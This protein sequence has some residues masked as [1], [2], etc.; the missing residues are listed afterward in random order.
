MT[1]GGSESETWGKVWSSSDHAAVLRPTWLPFTIDV[2]KTNYHVETSG[3]GLT[4]YL[5]LYTRASG[6]A[7]Q[8]L[9][10]A[11]GP[12]VI[13]G[14]RGPDES[15]D[16]VVVRGQGAQLLTSP[17]GTS[18][19]VWSEGGIR[20]TVQGFQ[21]TRGELLKIVESLMPVLDAN[22][23]VGSVPL[24]FTPPSGSPLPSS[25]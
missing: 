15:R 13:A 10:M 4:R 8:L 22:G 11:E 14:Q 3:R 9:F 24:I 12:D 19:V 25:R 5:V 2:T 6:P 23:G 18:R 7:P 16:D 17:D 1:P 21:L 20:Y